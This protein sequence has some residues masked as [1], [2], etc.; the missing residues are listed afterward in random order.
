M[1][2]QPDLFAAL[3]TL[4]Q[5]FGQA[6]SRREL[7]DLILAA[8]LDTL[9]AKS[10]CLYLASPE[11]PDPAPVAQK[12]FPARATRSRQSLLAQEIVPLVR[13]QGFVF[14]RDAA[15]DPRLAHRETQET[16]GIASILGVPVLV[17]GEALGVFCLLTAKPR[18]FSPQERDFLT[19]LAQQAGGVMAHARLLDQVR[20]K[21]RLF[22]EMA[23]GLNSSLDLKT[24]LNRMTEEITRA[25]RVKA[26]S[27]RLLDEDKNTLELVASY[28]LSDRYLGKGPAPA[29]QALFQALAG[30][31]VLIKDVATDR[32]VA[33]RQEKLAEGIASVLT[34]PITTRDKIIGVLRL[35]AGAP[36]EFSQDD[37]DL[38]AAL[39]HLGG[40]AIH[41]AALYLSCQ[42]D[43]QDLKDELWAHRSWF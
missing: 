10:V 41:N 31:A 4:S 32:R 5:A 39:A 16:K 30:K 22:L 37:L 20:Q 12:G 2:D 8:A 25:F 38:A 35:Y 29:D 21:T 18:D 7:L 23:A 26:V 34:V 11:R 17:K 13:A 9:G 3:C 40:L 1:N 28:G 36:R 43:F 27:I 15:S 19:V 6:G 24:V 14:I 33:Y 42:T